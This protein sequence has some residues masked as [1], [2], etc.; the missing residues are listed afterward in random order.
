MGDMTSEA[1]GRASIKSDLDLKCRVTSAVENL[2]SVNLI[3]LHRKGSNVITMSDKSYDMRSLLLDVFLD[4]AQSTII[5]IDSYEN[6]VQNRRLFLDLKSPLMLK[7][8][9]AL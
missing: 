4:H 1:T 9:T 7:K 6:R 3:D 8:K 5:N 2:S